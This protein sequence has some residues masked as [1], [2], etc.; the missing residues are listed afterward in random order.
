MNSSGN[1]GITDPLFIKKHFDELKN[2]IEEKGSKKDWQERELALKAM[3]EVFEAKNKK[4]DFPEEDFLN[5][6]FL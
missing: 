3:F 5:E 4:T 6:D 1:S 2:I